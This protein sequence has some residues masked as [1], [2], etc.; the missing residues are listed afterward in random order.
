M[1]LKD[2][3]EWLAGRANRIRTFDFSRPIQTTAVYLS[4]QAKKCFDEQRSPWGVPWAGWA[5]P[6]S[7]KR[8]GPGAKLLIDTGVLMG[9][10]SSGGSYHVE[11]GTSA[12]LLW[13]TS[14]PYAGYQQRGTVTIPARPFVGVS[15]PMLKRI[16][17]ILL[18]YVKRAF[19]P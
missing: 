13:G 7:K 1:D 12:S 9:S 17:D 4:S 14:V 18:D 11:E 15:E 8:G 16:Q 2:L 10:M 19:A 5:H 6:P 3:P